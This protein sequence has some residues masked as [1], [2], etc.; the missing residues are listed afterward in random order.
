[1]RETERGFQDCIVQVAKV[2]GWKVYHPWISIRSAP[3]WPDAVFVKAGE[4]VVYVEFKR[5]DGQLTPAQDE[6]LDALRQAHGTEVH[7]W[8]PKDYQRIVQRFAP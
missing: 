1:M 3:G 8:R 2:H 4:P 6:W 7:V 5:D